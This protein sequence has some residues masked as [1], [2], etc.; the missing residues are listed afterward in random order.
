MLFCQS[1]GISTNGFNPEKRHPDFLA[2]IYLIPEEFNLPDV[3][4]ADLIKYYASFYPNFDRLQFEKNILDFEVPADRTFGEMSLGQKKKA[5]ISFGLACNTPILLMD[6]P[7]NGLDILSKS[8]FKKVM[9]EHV[10]PSQCIIIS[11]HQVKDLENIINRVTII[12]EQGI[13]LDKEVEA[14]TKALYFTQS[15]DMQEV[16]KAIYADS[17]TKGSADI[18]VA[19]TAMQHSNLDL[20]LLYKAVATN[21]KPLL[22]ALAAVVSQGI[23]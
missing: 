2:S 4:V 3:R 6:E 16:E 19:N 23:E 12:D 21:P 1:G 15:S 22:E 17:F 20:E 14:I 11:T 5:V 10:K 9:C 7:T 8:Q 13:V 18:I